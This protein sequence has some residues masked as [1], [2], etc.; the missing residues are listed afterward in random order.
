MIDKPLQEIEDK[1]DEMVK[2][3]DVQEEH[4]DTLKKEIE[5]KET[6]IAAIDRKIKVNEAIHS[7]MVETLRD[8]EEKKSK[9]DEHTK[10][11]TRK[12]K[13]QE[14]RLQ[15]LLKDIT[16][17]VNYVQVIDA[18]VNEMENI[19]REAAKDL[20]KTKQR[21]DSLNAELKKLELNKISLEK[22]MRD[23]SQLVKSKRQKKIDESRQ[24]EM[25][26]KLYNETIEKMAGALETYKGKIAEANV[27]LR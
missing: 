9:K 23:Y 15:R 6:Y 8:M 22:E 20:F 17:K 18:K 4:F 12:I 1:G 14:K 25:E 3:I 27:T 11:N 5:A 24:F 2:K 19:T 21:R 10:M 7:E 13:A 26:V 16:T